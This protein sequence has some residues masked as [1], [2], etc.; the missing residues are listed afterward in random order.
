MLVTQ[1]LN[2]EIEDKHIR[3]IGAKP[4]VA[5]EEEEKGAN[6][7][8]KKHKQNTNASEYN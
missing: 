4:K 7:P 3:Y 5:D 8:N 6:S 1:I 2:K